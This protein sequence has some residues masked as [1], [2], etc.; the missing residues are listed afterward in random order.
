MVGSR[1]YLFRDSLTNPDSLFEIYLK[2]RVFQFILKFLPVRFDTEEIHFHYHSIQT[3]EKIAWF[4]I[5]SSIRLETSLAVNK[6]VA[7]NPLNFYFSAID[8]LSKFISILMDV[9]LRKV[10]TFWKDYVLLAA[11]LVSRQTNRTTEHNAILFTV[12]LLN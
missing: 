12:H 8:A 6:K 5:L 11:K 9:Q 7:M 1:D 4:L 10:T 2:A 3:D